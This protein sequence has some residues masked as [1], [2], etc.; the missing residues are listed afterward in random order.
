[1]LWQR[2]YLL[3]QTAR[4]TY[5]PSRDEWGPLA[6]PLGKYFVLG[7]NRHASFDSRYSGL[8][9]QREVVGT[10]E[11]RYYS[12]EYGLHR[13]SLLRGVRWDRIGKVKD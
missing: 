9:D 11:F 1:M 5:E 7:D 3:D 8:V 13:S 12:S 4:A 6:V 2:S 10:V